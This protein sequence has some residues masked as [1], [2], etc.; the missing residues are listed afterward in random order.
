[1]ASMREIRQRIRIVKNIEQITK[2]MKMVAA[3]RLKKA[4]DRAESARPYAERIYAMMESLSGSSAEINHPL[5]QVREPKNIG[6]LI[7][8]GERGM[9]GSYNVNVLREAGRLLNQYSKDQ[10]KIVAVGKKGINYLRYRGYNLIGEYSLPAT[11]VDLTL[12]RTISR[13]LTGLFESGQVDAVYMVYTRFVTA[14]SQTPATIKLLPIEPAAGEAE[15]DFIFEPNPGELLG[16]LLPRYVDTQILR[17]L[18]E[19]IASEHGARMTSMSSAT[20]NAGEMIQRLTLT[21]NRVRQAAIT[22]ELLEITAGAE[23]LKS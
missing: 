19:S 22:K 7:I 9:A 23:A 11:D 21:F 18:L 10:L 4:Q 16:S 12:L 14:M 3:A 15:S 13:T 5:M 6:V 1:M 20:E 8:S 2:A 17:G